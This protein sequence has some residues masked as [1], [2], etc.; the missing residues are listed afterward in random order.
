M[1]ADRN[2]TT[3]KPDAVRDFC[4][5]LWRLRAAGFG[6]IEQWRLLDLGRGLALAVAL[7]VGSRAGYDP[8]FDRRVLWAREV[9]AAARDGG[10]V[11]LVGGEL[12]ACVEF[13]LGMDEERARCG[14]E[15]AAGE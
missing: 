15:M 8:E 9:L 3:G 5:M 6:R 7:D 12:E 11:C 4:G 2:K 13:A 14:K 10:R 1:S